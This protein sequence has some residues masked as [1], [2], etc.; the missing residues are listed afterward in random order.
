MATDYLTF[1]CSEPSSKAGAIT[2]DLLDFTEPGEDVVVILEPISGAGVDWKPLGAGAQIEY[3]FQ[4]KIS[5]ATYPLQV[6]AYKAWR[7]KKDG[8][9]TIEYASG[10]YGPITVTSVDLTNIEIRPTNPLNA[11]ATATFQKV[12]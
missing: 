10:A 6:A 4:L 1:T 11:E 5:T 2:A 12:I 9:G 7:T 3:T 8:V